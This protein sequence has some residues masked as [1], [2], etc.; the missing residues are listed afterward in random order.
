MLLSRC[1]TCPLFM[2]HW[3]VVNSECMVLLLQL[4][5]TDDGTCW[6]KVDPFPT[7]FE[8]SFRSCFSFAALPLTEPGPWVG[9][10]KSKAF[11]S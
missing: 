9:F 2:F 8:S 4:Q 10:P 5:G 11:A 6:N 3:V 7:G 1:S